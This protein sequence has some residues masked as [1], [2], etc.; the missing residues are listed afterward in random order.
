MGRASVPVFFSFAPDRGCG[1]VLD[2]HP[3]V[4]ATGAIGRTEPLRDNALATER[5][6]LTVDD[7]AIRVKCALN[8]M[9]AC[10]PR[11]SDFR[12]LLRVSIGSRRKS[13]PSSSSRSKAQ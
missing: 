11:S 7:R 9:P 2:L 10:L 5:A 4:G 13:S 8:A 3:T 6:S 12:V 1:R